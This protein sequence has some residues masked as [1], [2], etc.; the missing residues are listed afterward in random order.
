MLSK[1]DADSPLL[2]LSVNSKVHNLYGTMWDLYVHYARVC[3]LAAMKD[4]L[5]T[6]S[7]VVVEGDSVYT[8]GESTTPAQPA[9]IL[10]VVNANF[11]CRVYASHD[12]G[13]AEAY[14][15]GDFLATPSDVKAVLDLWLQNRQNLSALTS[16]LSRSA[17]FLSALYVRAF[18]Q[19]LQNAK[20]NVITGYDV[21]NDFFKALLGK[22]MMY[23][24]AVFPEQ[25]GGVRGDLDGV[26][27]P[28]HLDVAQMHKLHMVLQ[29]ARVRSGDR[30]LEFGTGWG[31]LAIEAA[32]MGC[33]VD[34]LTLSVEQKAL[35]EERIATEGLTDRIRVHLLDYRNLP[36]EFEHQF[37][38][39]VCIEMVEHVGAKYLPKYFEIL[40][41]ALR[42]ERATA[43][44]TATTTPEF[45]F[46]EY[47]SEDYARRYQWPNAFCPSPTYFVTKASKTWRGRFV[48]ESVED[49]AH[50]Y[51]RT[52]REWGRRLQLSW[53]P[54]LVHSLVQAQPQLSDEEALAIFKRKWEYMCVYAEVGFARAYTSCHHFTFARPENVVTR[55]D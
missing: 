26:W 33:Y 1:S 36:Q 6:G 7:L 28:D 2:P 5:K 52:L 9:V 21:C 29:K 23:S 18:G 3:L 12:L 14:M 41:W 43:V 22:T 45:R 53:G 4:G 47:Q 48:L 24:C 50:H 20:L 39:F 34:T 49:Y 27:S 30:V 25:T 44:I 54:K 51:P 55:C 13:F 37:D 46:T 11:W 35:A 16:L 32:K 38:A 19:S 17:S 42:P 8:F 31:S 15:H 10:R 40:D